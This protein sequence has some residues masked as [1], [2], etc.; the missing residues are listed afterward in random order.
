MTTHARKGWFVKMYAQINAV[1]EIILLSAFF[2][3]TVM[4][5]AS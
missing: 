3:C 5:L 4:E 1:N 2:E